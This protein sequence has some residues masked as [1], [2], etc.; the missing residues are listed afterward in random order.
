M[1]KIIT[2]LTLLLVGLN[3]SC[4][5]KNPTEKE[6]TSTDEANVYNNNVGDSSIDIIRTKDLEV[7]IINGEK[8]EY[9]FPI[10]G[11]VIPKNSSDLYAEVQGTISPTNKPFK[12]GVFYKKG[13]LILTIN[14]NEF[15]NQLKAEK[16]NFL[17][18]LTSI[19]PDLKSDYPEG[20]KDWIQ[21]IENYDVN[22]PLNDIPKYNTNSENYFLT[23]RQIFSTY[24]KIKSLED[25]LGKYRIY[26]PYDGILSQ[27]NADLGSLVNPSQFLGKFIST[28][29][30]I[31]AGVS[32]NQLKNLTI[33]ETIEFEN[34]KLGTKYQAKVA[35]INS[36]LDV[37]TQNI[38]IYLDVNSSS[39]LSGIY[40]EGNLPRNGQ[41]KSFRIPSKVLKRDGSIIVLESNILKKR[42]ISVIEIDG[43]YVYVEGLKSGD[44]IVLNDFANP[45]SGLKIVD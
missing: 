21:F 25:R 2:L 20:Y 41:N 33:G 12:P 37:N 24:F 3:T 42:S 29:Y 39:L 5:D 11:R 4:G 1:K 8:E 34:K 10:T 35:R 31:E 30:E 7:L 36:I 43:E 45:V 22:N 18:L 17:G 27:T 6:T 23:S 32:I 26:A 14:S 28:Q 40:L 38:P 9:S 16:S 19:L 15:E 13:E 44:T